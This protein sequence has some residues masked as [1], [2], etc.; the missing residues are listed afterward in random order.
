MAYYL[1]KIAGL[2]GHLARAS[3]PP[4][5]SLTESW[6][7]SPRSSAIKALRRGHPHHKKALLPLRLPDGSTRLDG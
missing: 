4:P 5:A 6:T 2:G 3:D 7:G 1:I